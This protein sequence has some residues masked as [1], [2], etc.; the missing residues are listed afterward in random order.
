MVI[1]II[2]G[3]LYIR[4]ISGSCEVVSQAFFQSVILG[5]ILE[6]VGEYAGFIKIW[7]HK[8]NGDFDDKQE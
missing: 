6:L 8:D 5:G 4:C 1:Y 7:R 3:A 2:A